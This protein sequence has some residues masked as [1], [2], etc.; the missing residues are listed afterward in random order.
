MAN[1]FSLGKQGKLGNIDLNKIKSGITKQ[2][3]GIENNTVLASIFDSIDSGKGTNAGNGKL[4]RDELAEF[5]QKIKDLAGSDKD[6]TNLS[7]KEA[8]N[9]EVGDKKLGRKNNKEL[10]NFLNKLAHLT[11]GIKEVK[12][13]NG[14]ETVVY[15]DGHTE[16]VFANGEKIIT[17]NEGSKTIVTKQDKKGQILEETVKDGEIESKTINNPE[18]GNKAKTI[19][20]NHSTNETVIIEYE[21]DGVTPKTKSEAGNGESRKYRYDKASGEYVLEK[22][23]KT[24][25]SDGNKYVNSKEYDEAGY[26]EILTR[27]G[28]EI[29]KTKSE[30]G[31]I[32]TIEY[33]GEGNSYVVVQPEEQD[34]ETIAKKFGCT[35]EELINANNGRERF[36]VGEKIK[37]PKKLEPNAE[38][39]DGQLSSEDAIQKQ[40]EI[41]A[42]KEAELRAKREAEAR[43]ARQN[44]AWGVK[45]RKNYGKPVTCYS[46]QG[47]KR[48]AVKGTYI[49][50]SAKY[51]GRWVV[52][53]NGKIY[54]M[55]QY[56]NTLLK[57][58]YVKDPEAFNAEVKVTKEYNENVKTRKNA[59]GL[60]KQFYKIA[61]DYSGMTSLN[62]MQELLSTSVNEK[63]I[64]AFLDAYDKEKHGDSSIVDTVISENIALTPKHR[65]ILEDI[66]SKL[67]KAAANAG[68]SKSD[69]A[70]ANADFKAAL[71][72]EFSTHTRA[73]DRAVIERPIAFL[74]GCIVAKQ[75]ANVEQMSDEAAMKEFNSS[76]KAESEGAQKTYNDAKGDGW[77]WTAKTGDTV[78]GWFGCKTIEEMEA[79]LGKSAA[80]VKRLAKAKNFEEFKVI[81]KEIFGIEFDKNKIAARDAALAN[82]QQASVCGQTLNL[83]SKILKNAGS[84]DYNTLRAEIKSKFQFDDETVDSII[85][86][87]AKATGKAADSEAD[88]RAMLLE[89]LQNTQAETASTY[90]SLTKGKTLEQMGKDLE[91]LHKS[92][93]GTSDIANEVAEFT[94]NLATTEMI[95]EG[96]FEI[97]GT[98]ALQFV[99]GLGQMAA[100]RLAVSAAKWGT[101][102]VKIANAAK[103]A[104]KVFATIQ[105]ASTATKG[106]KFVST[107]ANAGVA[108][109]AVDLSNGDDVKSALKKALMNMSFAGVGVTSSMLAPKLMQALNIN[110]ALATEI[111][112]EIIN[113]AGAYGVTSVSGGEYGSQDAFIDFITGMV[114]ARVAHIKTGKH[115]EA[116]TTTDLARTETPQA[117]GNDNLPAPK[118]KEVPKTDEKSHVVGEEGSSLNN[119]EKANSLR[120]KL[121]ENLFTIYQAVERGIDSLKDISGYNKLK[122][123]IA[124]KFKNSYPE[125]SELITRLN[126]KAKKLG[127][128]VVETSVDRTAR[129]GKSLAKFYDKI[130]SAIS[131]MKDMKRFNKLLDKITTKFA[132]FKNDMKTLLDKLYDKAESLGLSI[133]ESYHDVCTRVGIKTNGVKSLDKYVRSKRGIDMSKSH[134]DWM[135][136]RKDLF[137]HVTPHYETCWAQYTPK[138]Q[139]HGAWKMHLY[140]VNEADWREMC[141]V[142]IPY[143]KEHDIEWKTFND[144][145]GVH[146]INGSKQQGKAFTIYP[147]NNE[148]MAQV[149]KDLDYIIR[150]NKLETNGSKIIGDNELGSSGRLFYRYE[151]NSRAYKDEILDLSNKADFNKYRNRYDANR[152]EGKYLADDM[153]IEDDIW[154]NF[155][156][157]DPNAQPAANQVVELHKT[158]LERGWKYHYDNPV[159]LNLANKVEIDL[160][161]PTIKA[162]IDNLPEGGRLTVGREGDIRIN[163]PSCT[164]SRI[165]VIIERHNGKIYIIDNSTNGTIVTS[166]Y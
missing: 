54:T 8:K 102:A 129:M 51:E 85:N 105:K 62:K 17:K 26:T 108:T 63:N 50:Q 103:K 100:A 20:T 42:K 154:R 153:T 44:A 81:Y 25:T 162:R 72:K 7:T 52:K 27:N 35:K 106:G 156:P 21:E 99:P 65:Q 145:S 12:V 118:Q 166:E 30:N 77:S 19:E 80:D 89:F 161:I 32:T 160:N 135:K 45:N 139:H 136:S 13:N 165:H 104:E 125:F 22:E 88:K 84:M 92:A 148:D 133:K 116:N 115:T 141:D 2:D 47:T 69:L 94:D 58:E 126:N 134:E 97:A 76:N 71:D 111:A 130:E 10:F 40:Q 59:E 143:L 150:K 78:L 117:K 64:V 37:V 107:V 93:F 146:D 14:S 132:N 101:K 131:S 55:S 119:P 24:T 158:A 60:A 138:N 152:G 66:F 36:E 112:E 121:G 74:R 164:V 53:V 28:K 46:G 79:K 82:Y 16:E 96:A 67:M 48:K 18:T 128:K 83:V 114:M 90:R 38:E 68:V 98:I 113:A 157:A 6:D 57:E 3:L 155:D 95:T 147:K 39:L 124:N 91:L 86:Q 123:V 137:D 73:T 149:A 122:I 41:N 61:D 109:V 9:F 4:E 87:Y 1:S 34:A 75:T 29:A 23:T 5:F 159:S 43:I 140:S 70:K 33:D 151:F 163:D 142:I 15:E 31:N 49:G 120:K 127:L 110:R 56:D 144:A 11:D